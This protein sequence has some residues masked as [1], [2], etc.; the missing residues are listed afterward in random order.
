M[1]VFAALHNA[2]LTY[3]TN[4]LGVS[5]TLAKTTSFDLNTDEQKQQFGDISSNA[6]LILAKEL[7][8]NPREI[9]QEITQKFSTSTIEK[10][11]M[12]G[13]GFLNIF[14]TKE[15]FAQLAQELF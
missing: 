1:N 4:K 15:T 13:P 7:K 14:L 6:A 10:L 12:A 8:R 11:E 2:F 3:L 5:L 9:A